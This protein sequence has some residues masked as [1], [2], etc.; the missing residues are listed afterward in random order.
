MLG[1]TCTADL[2]LPH[3]RHILSNSTEE[4]ACEVEADS[5]WEKGVA[6][7][8]YFTVLAD[9]GPVGRN[10]HSVPEEEHK[11]GLKNNKKAGKQRKGVSGA[12][13]A[14]ADAESKGISSRS[15]LSS[16]GVPITTEGP[17]GIIPTGN[18]DLYTDHEFTLTCEALYKMLI[19]AYYAPEGTKIPYDTAGRETFFMRHLGFDPLQLNFL[20]EDVLNS[21]GFEDMVV[22]QRP[23]LLTEKHFEGGRAFMALSLLDVCP[24]LPATLIDSVKENRDK[25]LTIMID[26]DTTELRRYI[27][28]TH[29]SAVAMGNEGEALNWKE[30]KDVLQQIHH[31]G[32]TARQQARQTPGTV[33]ASGLGGIQGRGGVGQAGTMNALRATTATT[34]AAATATAATAPGFVSF[35]TPPTGSRASRRFS[36]D[37]R[38]QASATSA[39]AEPETAVIDLTGSEGLEAPGAEE[40]V[41]SFGNM[42][43]E[44][45]VRPSWQCL[46]VLNDWI[47]S[48]AKAIIKQ[49]VDENIQHKLD[50]P[51]LTVEGLW[52]AAEHVL[53]PRIA[54]EFCEQALEKVKLLDVLSGFAPDQTVEEQESRRDAMMEKTWTELGDD[55]DLGLE[56]DKV[57][58][59][60]GCFMPLLEDD[61]DDSDIEDDSSMEDYD[62][63]SDS[64]DDFTVMDEDSDDTYESESDEGSGS[65]PIETDSSEEEEEGVEQDEDRHDLI[66]G[67]H[68][69]SGREGIVRN[70]VDLGPGTSDEIRQETDDEGGDI[71]SNSNSDSDS[72][73]RGSG[74]QDLDELPAT[75]GMGAAGVHGLGRGPLQEYQDV[76]DEADEEEE[77]NHKELQGVVFLTS[78]LER[79]AHTV[80]VSAALLVPLMSPPDHAAS[81]AVDDDDVAAA[82]EAAE[83][84]GIAQPAAAAGSHGGTYLISARATRTRSRATISS[85]SMRQITPAAASGHRPRTGLLTN[86]V[87]TGQGT[88]A[89][90]LPLSAVAVNPGNRPKTFLPLEALHIILATHQLGGLPM[91]LL[92]HIPI[93]NPAKWPLSMQDSQSGIVPSVPSCHSSSTFTAFVEPSYPLSL[94]QGLDYSQPEQLLWHWHSTGTYPLLQHP[95]FHTSH[96]SPPQPGSLLKPS[97]SAAVDSSTPQVATPNLTGFLQWLLSEEGVPHGTLNSLQTSGPST[98]SANLPSSQPAVLCPLDMKAYC[99]RVLPQCCPQVRL[100]IQ[101]SVSGADAGTE[102][103]ALGSSS[104]EAPNGRLSISPSRCAYWHGLQCSCCRQLTQDRVIGRPLEE[105]LKALERQ[106]ASA[107]PVYL[108]ALSRWHDSAGVPEVSAKGVHTE[109][110][111]TCPDT[112]RTRKRGGSSKARQSAAGAP[113]PSPEAAIAV[114]GVSGS[115]AASV[116]DNSCS[117][118]QK[119]A[120]GQV[121]R[122]QKRRRK[123]EG[124][125]KVEVT[126]GEPSCKD[127]EGQQRDLLKSVQNAVRSLHL[128]SPSW[129]QMLDAE[130]N[131][132]EGVNGVDAMWLKCRVWPALMELWDLVAMQQALCEWQA[133]MSHMSGQKWEGAQ[134]AG[135]V[136]TSVEEGSTDSTGF[137]KNRTRQR[138]HH[139]LNAEVVRAA[140]KDVLNSVAPYLEISEEAI[141]VLHAAMEREASAFFADRARM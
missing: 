57:A 117:Y 139:A 37:R 51:M 78:L 137:H 113:D 24:L 135:D 32:G 114:A 30:S 119:E 50:V 23:L 138:L 108:A 107:W 89:A 22:G 92:P 46:S 18:T 38:L 15:M 141:E 130:L 63:M 106:V 3:S 98:S 103:A 124:G 5:I 111:H 21:F 72:D 26:S 82:T 97:A 126:H 84:A 75:L 13:A 91:R 116:S 1:S 65:I 52:R 43:A 109:P 102:E 122:G 45:G 127:E 7:K 136:S 58:Y 36:R 47:V 101:P 41:S 64:E 34:A 49:L 96:T 56:V 25:L 33:T 54:E 105:K 66:R 9:Q 79:L 12:G 77:S 14:N 76:E 129:R 74:E 60:I 61:V 62:D 120:N 140:A 128:Y 112:G 28:K 39:V 27:S 132:G 90:R 87:S 123:E 20:R 40:E 67:H 11:T 86:E 68:T 17:S 110:V 6:E 73:S 100:H 93:L 121:G 104:T 88:G 8:L 70:L 4:P 85:P 19:A 71:G 80:I 29:V 59:L 133:L 2:P 48:L 10:A 83:H 95:M 131:V 81:T 125:R 94:V 31:H 134:G 69:N 55:L 53:P 35:P 42:G 44:V 118:F 99:G 16:N 115:K